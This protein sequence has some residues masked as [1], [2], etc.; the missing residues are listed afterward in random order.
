MAARLRVRLTPRAG[1]DGLDGWANDSD[2]R[3]Y[4]KARV[5]A[6]PVEGEANAALIVLIAKALGVAKTAV[7]IA[8]GE[9]ARIKTLKIEGMDEGD[10]MR[11]LG[12]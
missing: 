4:L 9:S 6:P 5:K 10:L 11:R 7:V 12:A 1:R 8:A 3:P 2:G